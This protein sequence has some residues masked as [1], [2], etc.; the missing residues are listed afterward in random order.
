MKV[1]SDLDGS[2][3]KTITD[4]HMMVHFFYGRPSNIQNYGAD[5]FNFSPSI[6]DVGRR[7][8]THKKTSPKIFDILAEVRTAGVTAWAILLGE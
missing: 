6:M 7:H 2:M 8:E 1:K 3:S 5:P 4:A